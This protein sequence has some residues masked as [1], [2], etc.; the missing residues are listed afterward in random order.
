MSTLKIKEGTKKI[1]SFQYKERKDI[2]ELIIADS[3][4]E[5]GALAFFGC[6]NLKQICWARCIRLM[7]KV[8]LR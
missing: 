2:E 1:D 6:I 3:V 4:E 7:R 5:I 8:D